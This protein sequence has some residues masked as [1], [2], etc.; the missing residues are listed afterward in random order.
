[1]LT[2]V[3]LTAGAAIGL[4]GQAQ[5][6]TVPRT[7]GANGSVSCLTVDGLESV[8]TQVTVE[9]APPS[10]LAPG[11]T[12]VLEDDVYTSAGVLT[13]TSRATIQILYEVPSNGHLIASDTET[14]AFTDGTVDLAGLVDITDALGGDP[15]SLAAFGI[16]G[17]Y[18]GLVGTLS[19]RNT[20]S[21]SGTSDLKLCG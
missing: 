20:S 11:E 1:V 2:L 8:E 10:G 14:L 9:N 6:Q 5:A 13:A 7:V 17:R 15:W 3:C 12:L 16:S 4:I 19:I 21:S 18:T